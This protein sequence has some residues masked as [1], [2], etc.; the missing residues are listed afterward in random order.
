M[1]DMLDSTPVLG[2]SGLGV[3]RSRKA[4]RAEVRLS[5]LKYVCTKRNKR[6]GRC[7]RRVKARFAGKGA[8]RRLVFPKRGA[9][10]YGIYKTGRK[11]GM[12]RP[13]SDSSRRSGRRRR[14][15]GRRRGRGRRRSR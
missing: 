13:A 10:K 7:L 2:A 11:A 14:S 12:C 8:K 4:N 5:G 9:C 1:F 6:T 15:S 3:I